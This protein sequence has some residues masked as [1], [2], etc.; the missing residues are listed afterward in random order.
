MMIMM[1]NELNF[2]WHMGLDILS[3]C[4][5]CEINENRETLIT[6]RNDADDR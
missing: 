5:C 1:I 3:S 6:I 4:D 2:T